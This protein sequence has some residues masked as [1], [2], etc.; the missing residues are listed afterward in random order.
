MRV[1]SSIA[2]NRSRAAR[3]M[4]S[5]FTIPEFMITVAVSVMVMAGIVA[6][7]LMG[8]RMFEMTKA[9]LGASDDARR[10]INLLI[11][12]I[13][14]A[15]V[16]RVG[17]GSTDT[18]TPVAGS[19]LQNGSA[20]EI[21]ASTNTNHWVRYYRDASDQ[22]IRRSTNGSSTATVVAHSVS[23]AAVFSIENYSGA[24]LTNNAEDYVVGLN[25]QFYQLQYPSV[26]IGPGGYFDYYQM[27]TRV[28]PRAR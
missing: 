19:A 22:T 24:V 11:S 4:A 16:I 12:E 27:Q 21:Y 26:S 18:F 15:K 20:I 13:R 14:S 2:A 5:G 6:C 7:H 1:S 28:T 10:S 9:K 23:N 25:L 8:L 3:N 17:S